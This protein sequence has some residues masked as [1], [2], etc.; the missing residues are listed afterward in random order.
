MKSMNSYLS[1]LEKGEAI[2]N[3]R[4]DNLIE[5]LVPIEVDIGSLSAETHDQIR[6]G[7]QNWIDTH[8]DNV[9]YF[10]KGKL[11]AF[12]LILGEVQKDFGKIITDYNLN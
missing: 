11:Y 7:S 12:R 4:K 3:P 9:F 2:F 1:R 8:G 10:T 5:V 6:E